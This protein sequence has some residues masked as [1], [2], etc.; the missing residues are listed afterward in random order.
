[1]ASR[2]L[3]FPFSARP[4]VPMP[5]LARDAA[6]IALE[7]GAKRRTKI[8][9]LAATLHC[10]IVGTCLTTAE[11]RAILRKFK[12]G[13]GDTPS[14]HAAH[15]LAVGAVDKRDMLAKQ[16]QKALDRRHAAAIARASAI[17]TLSALQKFWDDAVQSGE[18]PGPY[19]AVLTHPQASD[20]LIR[21]AF[22]DVHMLSHMVGASNR[23]DIKRLNELEEAREAL[24]AELSRQQARARDNIMARD[25]KIHELNALLAERIS[26]APATNA[27]GTGLERLVVDLRRQL[28]ASTQRQTRLDERAQAL[29]ATIHDKDQR[30]AAL[31][32]EGMVLREELASAEDGLAQGGLEHAP[33]RLNLAGLTFL[34]VGGQPSQAARLKRI[35]TEADGRLLH[36]D[37][38]VEES[39]DLLPGLVSRADMALFPVNFISHAAALAL[40][41]LCRNSG[42]R[43]VPLR[44]AGIASLLVALKAITAP[45][46]SAADD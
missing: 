41:R 31:E 6:E 21:R 20:T 35:V 28:E 36:H 8:W 4:S 24:Q 33:A 2:P 23:A 9:E 44:S 17:D 10:S 26:A 43:Y 11:L 15:A 27:D 7:A 32:R 46:M 30:I 34:Y 5:M 25:A 18:I 12:L 16:I 39:L 1:M 14:D 19:W 40:K 45:A 42:K 29:T 37:G 13:D 38:G 22:G 3:T